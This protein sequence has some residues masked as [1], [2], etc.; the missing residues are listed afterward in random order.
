MV[1]VPSPS[2]EPFFKRF[3]FPVRVSEFILG[4]RDVIMIFI[5]M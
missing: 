2:S 3:L 5:Y 1:K 4:G